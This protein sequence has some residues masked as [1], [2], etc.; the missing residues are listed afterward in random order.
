MEIEATVSDRYAAG[1]K[2][3]EDALCCPVDYDA[4]LLAMLPAE[5]IEKDYGCGDPSGYVRSGDVVLDLGS[6]GGKICYMAA[7]LVGREG[8]VIG[9]D[10]TDDML[11]LAR[12]YR[13]EMAERLGGHR[14]DFKKGYI[15]D[16]ALD[17][18]AL[19]DYLANHPVKNLQ[20]WKALE[21]W[22]RNQRSNTPLI[23]D[24]SISLV[25]SNCVLNLVA[26]ADRKQMIAE[27]FRVLE[28]GGRIAI[29]DIV[30]DE[31][32]PEQL[33]ND[34]K[35][36]SGCISGAFLEQ[37][38]LQ[39][40]LDTGFCAL[41][42]DKWQAEAWQ[43]VEGIEFRSVT[44][45]AIKPPVQKNR[46]LGQ[47]LLYRGPY[48]KVT[49]DSGAEFVRGV[50]SAVGAKTFTTLTSSAYGNDFVAIE[51]A[52]AVSS[53]GAKM[54]DDNYVGVREPAL[55]KGGRQTGDSGGGCC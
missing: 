4:S 37:E 13:D 20:D 16:L 35:L 47:A 1:A 30:C 2:Q 29:S 43:V 11:A 6:G 17:V 27:I 32:V 9:I 34:E 3:R 46:D 22:K 49:D 12:K 25:V 39:A 5:I 54:L 40:F 42:Y 51:P 50:R 53:C 26:K 15:Q 45:T 24:N 48:A 52:S 7:Q 18:E 10:M 23:A 19:N 55:T 33:Q 21:D 28:P 36:W 31:A 44:L 8:R 41:S 38:F 14:V